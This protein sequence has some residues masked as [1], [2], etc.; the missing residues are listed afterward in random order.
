MRRGV[1][2]ATLL[3]AVAVLALGA[4]A[5]QAKTVRVFAVGP[6]FS[7]DWV[8]TRAH[9]H[10][11]L[12]AMV[13]AGARD[14]PGVPQIQR[15][16][17][18]VRS[19]LLGSKGN[20][21]DLVT[22]PED[23]G[24]LAAFTGER[25]R[26]ARGAPDLVTSIATLIGSYAP[27][28]AY[29]AS[30]YPALA[31]R[32]IPTRLLAVSLTDT[33]VRSAVETYAEIADELDVYL[34]GGVNMV[35]DWRV[36]CVSKA[37]FQTLPGGV[38]CDE[39]NPAK[40]AA[41][42]APDEPAR[43]YA[44]EATTD[45]ASNMALVFGPDGKLISKQVKT[46]LTPVELPGQLDLLPG[47]VSRGLSALRTPVGT[48]GFVTSKDAWMPDVMNTL[49]SEHVDLLVQP[50]FFV[51]DTVATKG[52][53]APDNIKASGFSDVLRHPSIES[54]V[55][56][57][58]T[59]NVFDFSA[60]NQSAIAIK[61]RSSRTKAPRGRLVGQAPQPGYVAVAP[62]VI[63][64]PLEPPVL[65]RRR[66][67][68]EAGEKLLPR[69]SSPA[70]PKADEA[71]PCRGGQV[72][73]TIFA[74]VEVDRRP[75]LRR[76]KARKR[77]R[78]PFSVNRPIAPSRHPQ[79]NVALASRGQTVLAA[80]EERRD[81]R[82]RVMLARSTDGAKTWRRATQ[83][84]QDAAGEA[85]WPSVTIGPGGE[86]W[87]TWQAGERVLV[88]FAPDGRRFGTAVSPAGAARQRK[89]SIAA[90]GAGKAY[91]AWIDERDRLA[92]EDLPQA[93][94]HG[95]R[96][97]G[98]T[99][100]E[101]AKVDTAATADDLAKSLDHDWAPSVA[102]RGDDVVVAWL[103]FRQYDWD[104]VARRSADGGASFGSLLPVNDTPPAREA[105]NDTPRAA[106]GPDGPLV[107]WTDY[108]KRTADATDLSPHPLY[109]IDIAVPGQR[110]RQVDHHGGAQVNTFAPALALLEGGDAL[111]AWQDHATGPADIRIARAARGAGGGR[112]VRVDDTGAMGW[113]QWRP[114][115][116]ITGTQVLAAWEDE[117][118]GPPQVYAARAAQR[119]IP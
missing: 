50:E 80:Y 44:Y 9:F 57:E 74:D 21:R 113:N 24:L 28:N 42:R 3:V 73:A 84:S 61:P 93:N 27:V 81:D 89:P 114:A 6:K 82:D 101:V 66:A 75:A 49:D 7:L 79:R 115:L 102:A 18:D 37:S 20:P 107:A 39:E 63:D 67:L 100:G 78:T 56:P 91:L 106:V 25:G 103:N 5:S 111:V 99:L 55:L 117:R 35:Q 43:T 72:E 26:T 36:V 41:L 17:G 48:L 51:N 83:L 29:Y 23:L 90:T 116:A 98:A 69:D 10:D 4:A 76:K 16:A 95:A 38:G 30:K 15:G 105:L 71:G 70:C 46:Y 92:T 110:N 22:F 104:V 34:E 52:M 94:V 96:V 40:V 77:G 59:G 64:D 32:G 11:K 12:V 97:Q 68:G 87:V 65:D 45:K 85:R 54:M 33:F 108:R 19:H 109:D 88:A 60:D 86:A 31:N 1:G 8:D 62:W 119:S 112:A 47:D 14:R 53:W 118:D 13:D 2:V 58:L